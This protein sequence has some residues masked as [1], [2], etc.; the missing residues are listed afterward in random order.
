VTTSG[1]S[2]GKKH[3]GINEFSDQYQVALLP[4]DLFGKGEFQKRAAADKNAFAEV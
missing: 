4:T 1:G 3:E 2:F